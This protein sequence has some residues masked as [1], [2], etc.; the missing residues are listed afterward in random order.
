MSYARLCAPYAVACALPHDTVDIA[1]FS[2]KALAGPQRLALA[3]RVVLLTDDN[4]DQ[5][6]LAPVRVA[7]TLENGTRHEIRVDEVYGSP[8][9]PMTRA[10]HL[11]KFQR[12][13]GSAALPLTDAAGD[14]LVA[15]IDALES[16]ADVTELV[17]LLIA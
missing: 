4:P 5:N 12:N 13:W 7:V 2:P 1:D 10:A 9:R 11:A 8:S 16:R 3:G 6:A 14:A 17:D 15:E